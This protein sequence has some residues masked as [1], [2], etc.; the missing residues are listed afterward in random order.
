MK[1]LIYWFE[2]N[3]FKKVSHN[4]Q[5]FYQCFVV[6]INVLIVTT[7]EDYF[8]QMINIPITQCVWNIQYQMFVRLNQFVTLW[9]SAKS[10][11]YR[12]VRV[13]HVR[14]AKPQFLHS[15][16]TKWRESKGCQ[17]P[18]MEAGRGIIDDDLPNVLKAGARSILV[19]VN[20]SVQSIQMLTPHSSRHQPHI[21]Q[22]TSWAPNEM[23]RRV[24]SQHSL[25]VDHPQTGALF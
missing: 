24:R 4:E 22:L 6:H 18:L 17:F 9:L 15:T 10:N 13:V 16:A 11:Q 5:I 20:Q 21:D 23:G 2:C 25:A 7:S 12:A 3:F 8:F 19:L 14:F 1:I